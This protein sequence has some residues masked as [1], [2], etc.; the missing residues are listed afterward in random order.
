MRGRATRESRGA[1]GQSPQREL[2]AVLEAL[3]LKPGKRVVAS[4]R[5]VR[6]RSSSVRVRQPWMD[7]G[8]VLQVHKLRS[9]NLL[10]LTAHCDVTC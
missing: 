6:M 5:G 7:G 8:W 9:S 2:V 10:A 3:A 4:I 1:S